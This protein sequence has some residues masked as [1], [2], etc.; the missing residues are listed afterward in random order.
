MTSRMPGRRIFTTTSVPSCSCARCTCAIEAAASGSASK[1]A[2]TAS[3]SPPRS[4]RSCGAQ[5]VQRHRRHVA[6]QACANSAIQSGPNR[7][8]RPARIWPELDEGG[9][10]LLE[11]QAHLHRRFEPR[12]VG[13]VVA[14]Q[15]MAGAL[16][17]VG[18][19]EA[20][21]G[22]AEAVADQHAGDLVQAAQVARGAQGLDQHGVKYLSASPPAPRHAAS[23]G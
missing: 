16:Q 12:Q 14:V 19:A 20:A 2:N 4:S 3:G 23:R 15:H 5:L 1:R 22:V 11:R 13:G 9:A 8:A 6:V 21:H 10:Q 7:S 18:Q 17:R